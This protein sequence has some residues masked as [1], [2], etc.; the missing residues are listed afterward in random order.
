ME[1]LVASYLRCQPWSLG[2][3]PLKERED[4]ST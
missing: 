3:K 2:A 1:C 4:V